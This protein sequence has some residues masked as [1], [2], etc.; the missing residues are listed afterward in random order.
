MFIRYRITK[1][2][3][4]KIWHSDLAK[5]YFLCRPLFHFR[6]IPVIPLKIEKTGDKRLKKAN[7]KKDNTG[8]P[9]VEAAKEPATP[10]GIK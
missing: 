1:I 7:G 4:V 3:K 5:L 8:T 10:Q 9:S 6:P 2:T